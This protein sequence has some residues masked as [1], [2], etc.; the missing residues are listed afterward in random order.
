M[1]KIHPTPRGFY[2]WSRLP[3]FRVFLSSVVD[4]SPLHASV[5]TWFPQLPC[6]R[7]SRGSRLKSW[8]FLCALCALLWQNI[9]GFHL[10]VRRPVRR[11][12]LAKA[13]APARRWMGLRA[14]VHFVHFGFVEKLPVLSPCRLGRST[15]PAEPVSGLVRTCSLSGVMA[16]LVVSG[17]GQ[18]YVQLK[19]ALACQPE[20]QPS[21]PLLDRRRRW[22][23]SLGS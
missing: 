13:E 5:P 14:C 10:P 22:N 1:C 6:S 16:Q 11:S 19:S 15:F 18:N 8:P 12:A 2:N 17:E 4:F 3:F 21:S 20:H 23:L 7:I 9:S